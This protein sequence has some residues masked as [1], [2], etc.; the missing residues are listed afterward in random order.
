VQA[1]ETNDGTPNEEETDMTEVNKI[2]TPRMLSKLASDLGEYWGN[3]INAALIGTGKVV[4]DATNK[5]KELV[6]SL[7]TPQYTFQKGM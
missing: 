6:A 1:E 2:K 4:L 7:A 3:S 5:Y